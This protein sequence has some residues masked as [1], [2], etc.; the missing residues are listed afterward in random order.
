[1]ITEDKILK[2]S[3]EQVLPTLPGRWWNLERDVLSH[4]KNSSHKNIWLF[5]ITADPCERQ[6]VSDQRPDVVQRLLARL[7]YYNQTAVPVYFPPDDPRA[8]PSQQSGAWVPWVDE[9]EEEEGKYTGVYK[10]GRLGKQ[11]KK[12]Q[13]CRLCKLQSFFLKLNTG[14]MSNRI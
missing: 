2:I 13:K 1:M 14:M 8:D 6:D 9:E 12:K 11:K 4:H 10:K 5:N 7:A 3:P